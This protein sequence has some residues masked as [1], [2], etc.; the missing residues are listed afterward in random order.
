MKIGLVTPGGFDRSGQERVIPAFLW[1]VER[2][3]RRHEVHVYTLHQYPQ[4]QDYPL[5]GATIHNIG[6]RPDSWRTP[7]QI[8]CALRALQQEHRRGRFDVLHGLWLGESGLVAALA[9]RMGRIPNVVTAAGGELVALPEVGYGGQL[10]RNS[11][12]V[13]GT[14]LRLA[15]TITVASRYMRRLLEPRRAVHRVIP[16]GVDTGCFKPPMVPPPGPPWRLLHVASLNRVKDQP[17]L[18]RAF[19]RIR[20]AEPA[21]H[22][23]IIGTDTLEGE[24]QRLAHT[25]GLAEA[26]TFHGFQPSAVVARFLQR[27]HLLLH[28]SRHE[29]GPLV[30]LEAAA[31]GVA[32]V[33]TAVGHI[34][35]LAPEAAAAVPVGDDAT[36]AQV[37]LALLHDNACRIALGERALD[38]ARAHDA[39]WTARQYESL[40]AEIGARSRARAKKSPAPA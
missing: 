27:S 19:Q 36:L 3:A 25:L 17:T 16:L 9:G 8:A 14:T 33:G 29:A 18:L 21:V 11:R 13:I 24:T 35:D 20:A 28:S 15:Q 12:L 1:L 32:T 34:D 6:Y 4:P 10:S 7:R 26:A 22:L 2:L 37:T 40:Y 38:F 31:C 5:L 39:E 30:F 23:D